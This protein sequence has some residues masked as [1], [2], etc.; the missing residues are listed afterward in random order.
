MAKHDDDDED[1]DELSTRR[2]LDDVDSVIVSGEAF[3]DFACLK[4]ADDKLH[5]PEETSQ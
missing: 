4:D 2:S 5:F 1:A 3:V